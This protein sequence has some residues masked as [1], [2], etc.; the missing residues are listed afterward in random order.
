MYPDIFTGNRPE[1]SSTHGL[2]H[3]CVII[4]NSGKS[5]TRPQTLTATTTT[6]TTTISTYVEQQYPLLQ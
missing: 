2:E 5:A 4:F 1:A 3:I 6:T